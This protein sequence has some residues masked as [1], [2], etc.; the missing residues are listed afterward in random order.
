M[1]WTV[2][3]RLDGGTARIFSRIGFQHSVL[4]AVVYAADQGEAYLILSVG[5]VSGFEPVI[6]DTVDLKSVFPPLIYDKSRSHSMKVIRF[7]EKELD[8]LFQL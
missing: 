6:R 1:E 7:S 2:A 5:P 3:Y 4:A 8:E